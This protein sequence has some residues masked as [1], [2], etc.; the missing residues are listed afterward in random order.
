VSP[1]W[2]VLRAT[3]DDRSRSDELAR[4]AAGLLPPGPQV[5]HDLGSGSGA[6]M[7]WL[8]PRLPGPQ[9]WVLHDAD[10]SIL[11]HRD[12]DP[13]ADSCG[14]PVVA[15]P[16]VEPLS[17]LNATALASATMIVASALLDVVTFAEARSIV[18]ACEV[19]RV[20][21]LFSLTVTG[22]VELE[23]RLDMDERF[24]LAFNQHQRREYEGRRLLGPDAS[25][26]IANLFLDAG[27]CVDTASTPWTL[28]ADDAD[29]TAEWLEGWLAAA[30]EEQP[31]LGL[32]AS[33]Y[34][35]RR[36]RQLAGGDLRVTVDHEDVLAWPA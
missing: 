23:P 26:V 24:G 28:T 31:R 22:R 20:P 30:V 19:L 21:A 11:D 15:Q 29:L 33:D 25:G 9:R 12:P 34:R 3:V 17:E 18:D 27:W 36:L 10:A 14:L 8:A 32:D 1:D 7:R 13:V 5:V 6:M 2:L 35:A 16:S 4:T